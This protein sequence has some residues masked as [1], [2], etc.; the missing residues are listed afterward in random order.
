M[1]FQYGK[2]DLSILQSVYLL[3]TFLLIGELL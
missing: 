3:I 1:L 2:I